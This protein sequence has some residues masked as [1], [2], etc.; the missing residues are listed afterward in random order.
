MHY[1]RIDRSPRLQRAMRLLS[2]GQWHT[3]RDIVMG[4]EVMAV[5]SAMSELRRNGL[6]IECELD[7]GRRGVYR[8]RWQPQT[9]L[10]L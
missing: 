2:D 8:Y 6:H 3:T 10:E 7:S 5:N 1:A 9:R 4:A